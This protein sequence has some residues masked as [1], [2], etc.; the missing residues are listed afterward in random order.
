MNPKSKALLISTL[1]DPECES[2]D[3]AGNL[4]TLVTLSTGHTFETTFEAA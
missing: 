1:L 4:F 2:H 3:T